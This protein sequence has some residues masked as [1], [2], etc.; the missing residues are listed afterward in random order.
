VTLK[1]KASPGSAFGGWSGA[2][3]CG[4]KATCKLRATTTIAVTAK[5]VK[6]H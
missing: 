5:F 3:G 1:A 2:V 4:R 6:K